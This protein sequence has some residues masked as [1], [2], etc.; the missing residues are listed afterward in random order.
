MREAEQTTPATPVQPGTGEPGPLSPLRAFVLLL[1]VLVVLMAF[2]AVFVL[3]KSEPSGEGIETNNFALTDTEAIEVFRDKDD[4]GIA[5]IQERDRSLVSQAFTPGGPLSARA[6]QAI[7]E[8]Q[9]D[10]V[11]D[12]IRYQSL[13]VKVI[14]NSS[15]EVRLRQVRLLF[16]CFVS[17]RGEDLTRDKTVVRQVVDWT[18]RRQQ[19]EWLLHDAELAK[20]KELDRRNQ[21]CP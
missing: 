15:R 21:D 2:V 17:E 8:L 3:R 19:S 7:K 5:A 20:D 6:Y 16:P 4:L 12:R 13:Q 11:T 18:L 14:E 1:T 9:R 10:A